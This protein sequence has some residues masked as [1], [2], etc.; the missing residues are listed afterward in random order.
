M[1]RLGL[2]AYAILRNNDLHFVNG[3]ISASMK[4]EQ[5][6]RSYSHEAVNRFRLYN[7]SSLFGGGILED[8]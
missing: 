5:S 1:F 7:I 4:S 8:L 6:Q 3:G 2:G